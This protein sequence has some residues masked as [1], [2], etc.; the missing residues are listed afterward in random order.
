M[1]NVQKK[2][3]ALFKIIILFTILLLNLN[4]F[5]DDWR[6]NT[7]FFLI[8][9]VIFVVS[10]KWSMIHFALVFLLLSL[11]QFILIDVLKKLPSVGFLVPFIIATLI[12]LPFS[13]TRRALRWLRAGKLDSITIYLIIG[14]IVVAAVS[15]ILWAQWTD[16][17]GGAEYMIHEY[18]SVP[19]WQMMLLAIPAFAVVNA[20]SEEVVYRGVLQNATAGVF[21]SKILVLIF[22]SSA[23]AAAHFAFGFPNGFVGYIM[24]FFYG[25]MLGYLKIRSGGMLAPV[26]THF[27]ADLTIGYFMILYVYL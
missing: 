24:V 16:F 17:L 26:L 3:S 25:I 1:A 21:E 5:I 23:F 18:A 15:L 9:T 10:R 7:A 2:H 6:I 12:V 14:T 8:L 20:F 22:Q 27:F 13:A 4:M 19:M 11:N